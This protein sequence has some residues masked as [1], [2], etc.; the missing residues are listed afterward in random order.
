MKSFRALILGDS[1]SYWKR[2]IPDLEAAIKHYKVDV[3][4]QVGD[5]CYL[6]KKYYGEDDIANDKLIIDCIDNAGIPFYWIDGNHEDHSILQ[7]VDDFNNST[8]NTYGKN[9]IYQKRGSF[10]ELDRYVIFFI[11][12]AET[13]D[14]HNRSEGVDF[15]RNE[16]I[17]RDQEDFIFSQMGA[18]KQI[19]KPIIVIAHTCPFEA[20]KDERNLMDIMSLEN[21]NVPSGHYQSKFLDQVLFELRPAMWFHGH[22]HRERIYTLPHLNLPTVFYSIGGYVQAKYDL[23]D[24]KYFII[25]L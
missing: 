2:I 15:F 6:P 11:G 12:G 10:L 4:I 3:V 7:V 8:F 22:Y 16:I 18:V 23:K 5:L 14:S 13:R 20:L 1:H 19:G 21:S 17:T 24:K 25:D 9:F